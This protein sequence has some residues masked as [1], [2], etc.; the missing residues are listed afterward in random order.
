MWG[1]TENKSDWIDDCLKD[2]LEALGL[3][4]ARKKLDSSNCYPLVLTIVGLLSQK[5]LTAKDFLSKL[6]KAPSKHQDSCVD[7][8][9]G[10][11]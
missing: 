6:T 9:G 4:E 10:H 5:V 1:R 8:E 3:W 7:Q 2:T 11:A